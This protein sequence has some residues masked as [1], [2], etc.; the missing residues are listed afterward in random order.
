MIAATPKIQF[1]MMSRGEDV[2]GAA[3][4]VELGGRAVELVLTYRV[5]AGR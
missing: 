2:L 5:M 4:E 1:A 3:A